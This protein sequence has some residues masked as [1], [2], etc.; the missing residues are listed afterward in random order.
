MTDPQAQRVAEIRSQI[1]DIDQVVVSGRF[2]R[3]ALLELNSAVSDLRNRMWALVTAVGAEDP[4]HALARLRARR[5]ADMLAASCHD[6][7]AGHIT[8]ERLEMRALATAC[9]DLLALN[10]G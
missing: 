4:A 2:P 7:S 10:P 9:R 5:A 6:L 1:A 8:T 3:D